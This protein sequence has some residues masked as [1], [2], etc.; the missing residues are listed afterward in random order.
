[1]LIGIISLLIYVGIEITEGLGWLTA[2]DWVNDFISL[3]GVFAVVIV[4]AISL[5][6]VVLVLLRLFKKPKSS[7]D[8]DSFGEDKKQG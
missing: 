4:V 1:M 5:A 3:L 7:M 6:V 2:Q 8:W